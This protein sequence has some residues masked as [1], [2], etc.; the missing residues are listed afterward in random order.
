MLDNAV[1]VEV[2]TGHAVIGLRFFRLLFDGDRFSSLIELNDT[3]TLRIIDI[4]AE[5]GCAFLLLC[6]CAETLL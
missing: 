6:G 5:Y 2:K 1:I 3:E 4:V